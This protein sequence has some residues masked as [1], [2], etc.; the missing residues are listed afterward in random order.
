MA[1]MAVETADWFGSDAGQSSSSV[2]DRYR[3]AASST[4]D[5]AQKPSLCV[6]DVLTDVDESMSGQTTLT[7]YEHLETDALD[8][9]VEASPEKRSHVEVRF[10]VDEYLV[11]VRSTDTILVYEPD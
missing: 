11:V 5:S 8:D 9:M 10:T 3:L 2:T 6:V 7:L 4:M 1:T